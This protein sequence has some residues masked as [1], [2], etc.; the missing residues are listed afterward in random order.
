MSD[1]PDNVVQL[2]REGP[3]E[4]KVQGMAEQ[5]ELA[6]LA[7]GQSLVYEE[8]ATSLKVAVSVM[9]HLVRGHY[10]TGIITEEQRDSLQWFLDTGVYAA[11]EMHK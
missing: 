10:E 2:F 11:D 1:V 8:T 4:R 5:W 9:S 7:A 3:G 6:F